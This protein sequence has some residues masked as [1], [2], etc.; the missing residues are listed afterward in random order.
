MFDS[1]RLNTQAF[2]FFFIF[3]I[4]YYYTA[5]SWAILEDF[6]KFLLSLLAYWRAD[7]IVL[8]L[9]DLK[10]GHIE[11]SQL[12]REAGLAFRGLKSSYK[13]RGGEIASIMFCLLEVP[14]QS[15][16]SANP[17]LPPVLKAEYCYWWD[18]MYPIFWKSYVYHSIYL[19]GNAGWQVW[20]EKRCACHALWY[21]CTF[22]NRNGLQMPDLRD[23][24]F[25]TLWP[26]A[27]S[28]Y[29]E[30][31][32]LLTIT[33][34]HRLPTAATFSES[35]QYSQHAEIL[36]LWWGSKFVQLPPPC[37]QCDAGHMS[38]CLQFSSH[39]GSC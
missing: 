33:F 21:T 10:H 16:V 18:C 37:I 35:V 15:I 28:S 2:I 11:I 12:L 25:C 38:L 6:W 34:A 1:P 32:F 3:E 4:F 23:Y 27:Q 8:Y 13:P 7:L 36:N 14:S 29:L 20:R 39:L 19:E 5:L 9:T 26:H 24:T 31:T 22:S 17:S 30:I